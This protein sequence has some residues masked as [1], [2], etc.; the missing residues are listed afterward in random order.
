MSV[1]G[2][3]MAKA[4]GY[5][6]PVSAAVECPF[7]SVALTCDTGMYFVGAH[8]LRLIPIFFPRSSWCQPPSISSFRRLTKQPSRLPQLTRLWL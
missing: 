2:R 3:L 8:S 4:G 6:P 1:L 5:G 7:V